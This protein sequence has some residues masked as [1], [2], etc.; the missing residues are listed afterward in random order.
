MIHYQLSVLYPTSQFLEISISFQVSAPGKISLKLP[1]WRAGR[2]QEANY[3]KF[4]RDFAVKDFSGEEVPFM[5]VSKAIWQFEASKGGEYSVK[6]Q[7][8]A[9]QMDAGSSWID[10]E[11]VYLNLVNCCMEVSG[12]APTECQVQ[13]RFPYPVKA[14]TLDSIN[15]NQFSASSFQ[16]LADS[17][18]LA[19]KQIMHSKFEV[20]SVKFHCWFKGDV[21]FNKYEFLESLQKVAEKLINDFG[22]FP[23][24]EYH[25]IFQLLPYTHYHGVE[26]RRGTVITYGTAE[27]LKNPKNYHEL[28]GI[29]SHELYHAW[30]VCRIR[31]KALLPYDFSVENYTE[32]G[33]ILEGI[34]SYMGDLYLLKSGF[35]SLSEFLD[36]L[37]RT[38]QRVSED[39]G[40]RH[41]SILE[42]SFDTWVDGY[43]KSIPDRRQNI[44]S[45]GALIALALDIH[46]LNDGLSLSEFMRIAWKRFGSKM[47]GYQE[48]SFWREV[49]KVSR[50]FDF[51]DFYSRYISGKESIIEHLKEI[52]PILGIKLEENFQNDYLR[53]NLGV[54]LEGQSVKKIH[55]DSFAY[56]VLMLGDE[57]K[58]VSPKGELEVHRINGNSYS[59]KI[60]ES[61]I[62]FF[63]EYK[64]Q[65]EQETPQR[66]KWM[67]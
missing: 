66:E 55:P 32:S 5:K 17:T 1:I 30:N 16:Q 4:I 15:S 29:S 28:M 43:Q 18:I 37:Q 8:F 64:F 42:S 40:W 14:T 49:E 67:Q 51:M 46:L 58:N 23:E 39:F 61:S 26:H 11:Q 54:L 45:N 25:F 52:L 13:T 62:Q 50:K 2:Y 33:W 38:V 24:E 6:Y 63:P 31:P 48:Y 10:D 3:A 19:T 21:Y 56:Q 57:I 53:N 34:T 36:K 35:W 47:R 7:F 9:G 65:I 60:K 59:Y 27:S 12:V 22:V 20:N 41:Q 44:Y